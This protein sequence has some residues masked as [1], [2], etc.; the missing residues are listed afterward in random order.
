MEMRKL[1][2]LFLDSSGI[3]TDTRTIQPGNLF[4]ALTGANFNGNQYAEQALSKGAAFAV[5]DD[6][7]Y[8][9]ENTILVEDTLQTL[10]ALANYHR[11]QLSIPIVAITGSNGK[12]TTKELTHAVLSKRYKTF[13]TKGNLN[14]HIGVPLSILS[15]N[16]QHEMAIIEMGANHLREIAQ[17]CRI[18]MP[19]YG[20]ITNV[21]TAHIEGFGS[22]ENIYKG[23][24]ELFD[25]IRFHKKS[26][27]FVC[28]DLGYLIDMSEGIRRI[29]YGTAPTFFYGQS[30]AG[31][32]QLQL[33]INNEEDA[34]AVSTQLVGNYN[35][36]NALAAGCI[37][38]FF[39][40]RLQQIKAAL[41]GYRPQN[42]RSQWVKTATNQFVLDA[43]NANPSSMQAALNHFSGI[44]YS[45]KLVVLGDML[46]LGE[47]SKVEHEKVVEL[48]AK[49]RLAAF[50]VGPLFGEVVHGENHFE[51]AQAF[52]DW[53]QQQNIQD[54]LILVKG[55][56][57]I[58]L[59][60][61]FDLDSN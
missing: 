47:T 61:A 14:N 60:T 56:R 17:L 26:G 28:N 34:M 1:Y 57:G 30:K 43:Y 18:A 11:N 41:E 20:L 49:L 12:T 51:N 24:G 9:Q 38:Q 37:G 45:N 21:G 2:K 32:N 15:I 25:Y 5:I 19:D 33:T 46:E 23:K 31:S 10:Q 48:A 53:W 6:K 39:G 7:Q 4:F 52:K 8:S 27:V 3:S 29:T 22:Q 36:F 54:H 35:L 44:D 42:N 13:A 58:K 50:Y 40:V 55:S 16:A 59:E